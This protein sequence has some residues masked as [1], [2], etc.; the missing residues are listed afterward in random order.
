ML[1]WIIPVLCG[2]IIHGRVY[3][4]SFFFFSPNHPASLTFVKVQLITIPLDAHI[5]LIDFP[6][7]AIPE[8]F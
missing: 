1:S 6:S 3:K 5:G 8:F 2:V 4:Y 7:Q